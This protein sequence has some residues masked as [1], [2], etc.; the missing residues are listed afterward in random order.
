[1]RTIFIIISSVLTILCTVPY[2]IDIVKGK[3]K[4]RVVSWFT[5]ALL[6]AVAGAASLSSHQYPAAILCACA[7]G[8]SLMVASLG[9]WK[10]GN[11]SFAAFDLACQAA[12]FVGLGLWFVFDS[13]TVAVAAVVVI[14]LVASMP[15]LKHAWQAP[16]E[17]T[18]AEYALSGIA[19][20]FTLLAATSWRLTAV[21]YPTYIVFINL[22]IVSIML[23]RHKNLSPGPETEI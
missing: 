23:A 5:W 10:H 13:P 4:P 20:I 7:T 11:A 3:T 15:T 6:T 14:D 18:L 9:L 2:L 1:M 22:L 8:E 19:G 12:A 16:H 21:A 17:E